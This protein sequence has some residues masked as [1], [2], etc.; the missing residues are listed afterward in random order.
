MSVCWLKW[1]WCCYQA[2]AEPPCKSFNRQAWI[3]KC[4]ILTLSCLHS[5]STVVLCFFFIHS[6]QGHSGLK[7]RNTSRLFIMRKKILAFQ[8][9]NNIFHSPIGSVACFVT[10]MENFGNC[11]EKEV[12]SL[13]KKIMSSKTP[14]EN[15]MM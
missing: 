2:T 15:V 11:K 14:M 1:L 8:K 12:R 3:K 4:T 13:E 7:A 5:F 9:R 6:H 10:F